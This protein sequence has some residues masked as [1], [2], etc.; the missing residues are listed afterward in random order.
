MDKLPCLGNAQR[1]DSQCAWASFWLSVPVLLLPSHPSADVLV[2]SPL[3]DPEEKCMYCLT[4]HVSVPDSWLSA[5]PWS[6]LDTMMCC[7][8]LKVNKMIGEN[9]FPVNPLSVIISKVICMSGRYNIFSENMIWLT[10]SAS[11]RC[12][13]LG[14]GVLFVGLFVFPQVHPQHLLKLT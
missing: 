14:F 11:L 13:R 6:C 5:Y 3:V 8:R 4:Y 12:S 7:Q 9:I 1:N 2:I 10:D